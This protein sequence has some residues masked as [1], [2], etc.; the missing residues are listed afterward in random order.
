MNKN[1]QYWPTTN[2]VLTYHASL[3]CITKIPFHYLLS[4]HGNPEDVNSIEINA[5]RL[6]SLSPGIKDLLGWSHDRHTPWGA[7]SV[8][9]EQ[10]Q[11]K[12]KQ[13]YYTILHLPFSVS[14][15]FF[16]TLIPFGN[17]SCGATVQHT[18]I[19]IHF[20]KLPDTTSINKRSPW[21]SY[22]SCHWGAF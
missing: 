5:N 12:W 10:G 9:P 6:L 4:L 13:P 15:S 17:S 19:K 16:L 14:L 18:L 21:H 3:I 11:M 22:L 1:L 20:S 2:L 8:N 7:L